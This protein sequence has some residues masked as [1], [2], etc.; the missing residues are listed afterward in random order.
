MGQVLAAD[1]IGVLSEAGGTITLQ[2]SLI[3]VGGLQLSTGIITV[4]VTLGSANQRFQVF[5][6]LNSGAVNLVVSTNE[7]SVGPAGFNSWTLVGSYYTSGTNPVTFGNFVSINGKP[8]SGPIPFDM[9]LNSTGAAI[10]RGSINNE[11]ATWHRDGRFLKIDFA[12][13]QDN[14]GSGSGT[15][16]YEIPF[17]TPNEDEIYIPPDASFASNGTILGSGFVRLPGQSLGISVAFFNQSNF[18]QMVLQH[19]AGTDGFHGAFHSFANA[20]LTVNFNADVS[21]LEFSDTPIRDL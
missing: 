9:Q 8:V 3:T 11:L 2:P 15:Y 14:G 12:Y 21:I 18:N 5:A 19:V 17:G 16:L 1:R 20:D 4:P 10:V 7:N 6:V 13:E